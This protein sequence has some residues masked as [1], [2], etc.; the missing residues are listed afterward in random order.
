MYTIRN[1]SQ[2]TKKA[3]TDHAKEYDLTIAEALQQLVELGLE[4]LEQQKKNPKKYLNTEAAIKSMPK[5]Q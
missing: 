2:N 1:L 3:I 5:W 4:Y